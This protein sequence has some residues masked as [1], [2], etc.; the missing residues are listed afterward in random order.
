MMGTETF[1]I[2]IHI[3]TLLLLFTII[4]II[5]IFNVETYQTESFREWNIL[6]IP[7]QVTQVSSST[8][9]GGTSS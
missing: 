5:I 4:I 1:E 8:C 6:L 2:I 7:E 9:S 3:T